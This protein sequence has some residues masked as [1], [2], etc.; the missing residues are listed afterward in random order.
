M[1]H[2]R[3]STRWS[4]VFP[5][6]LCV[7]SVGSVVLNTLHHPLLGGHFHPHYLSDREDILEGHGPPR[8][9]GTQKGKEQA[10]LSQRTTLT[11]SVQSY[12]SLL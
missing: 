2:A 9:M 11:P 12:Q 3:P 6:Y 7:G 5:I 8:H 10:D 1:T 4:S